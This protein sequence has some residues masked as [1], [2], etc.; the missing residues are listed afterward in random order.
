M[1]KL[2][3]VCSA[4]VGTPQPFESGP[5]VVGGVLYVTTSNQTFALNAATC[6]Q[7]WVNT[8]AASSGYPNRGAAYA[9]GLIFRGFP[10]GHVGAL[11]ATTGT[12]VWDRS[13]IA[14]G[15]LEFITGAPI[16]W[17]SMV[18]IGTAGGENG[19]MCHVVAL[20]Q[21]TGNVLW[22]AQTVPNPGSTAAATWKGATHIAGG[23]SW[24]SLTV[25]PQT[26]MLYVP[27]GNPGPDYDS[28]NRTGSNLYTNAVLEIN[29]STGA[30]VRAMQ[31]VLQDNHD[32]DQAATPAVITLPSGTRIALVG[33]KDGYLRSIDV[34]T[35][36]QHW[37][38][39]VTTI[40]NATA[41]ITTSGTHFCPQGGVVW[42]GAA[43][44]PT[45]ALAYVNAVD[46]CSTVYLEAKPVSYVKGKSWLGSS[47]VVVDAARSGWLSAIDATTG[48]ARSTYHSSKPLVAGV[49]PTAGGLVFTADLSGNVLA[50]NATTGTLLRTVATNLPVGGGVISYQ[51]AGTQYVAAAAG[52][53]NYDFVT[54][55]STP[56]VVVLG[57]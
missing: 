5:I 55:K 20:D 56:T 35:F 32:W 48:A 9:G 10:N 26:G 33:G 8:N 1:N 12:S 57:L 24:T 42:N 19:Q 3:V 39:A 52:M 44:A 50:F 40:S 22:S 49:T 37:S 6:K 13:A 2:H 15:S 14:A 47:N 38:T 43:Y 4:T 34:N 17:K 11:N 18:I 7:L 41:P 23:A 21:R 45:T 54:P 16:V 28:R 46:S 36:A 53:Y 29:P 27:V 31:F 51:V 30:F 25:D